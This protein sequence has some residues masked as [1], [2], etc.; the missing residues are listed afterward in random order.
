M[1]PFLRQVAGHYFSEGRLGG[2]CFVFPNRRALVFFKKYLVEFVKQS[3]RPLLEPELYTMNDFFYRITGSSPSGQ[4]ALLLELYGC[5]RELNPA[6]ESLDEFIFWGGVLLS[7]FNDIDKYLVRPEA[8][9]TNV[10]EFREMQDGYDYL[11]EKQLAGFAP[12]GSPT[13]AW[14]TASSPDAFGRKPRPTC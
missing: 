14:S 4:V 1:T 7:D 2:S 3:G 9:F 10:A 11:D 5:Y 12:R 8:L 13:R 6:H